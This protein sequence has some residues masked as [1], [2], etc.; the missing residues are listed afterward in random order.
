MAES[1]QY[2]PCKHEN[3]N[4]ILRP[5]INKL[6]MMVL[7]YDPALR[8]W[9]HLDAWGSLII[10]PSQAWSLMDS[11][12]QVE[13]QGLTLWNERIDCLGPLSDF[14][15]HIHCGRHSLPFFSQYMLTL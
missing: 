3:L 12:Q 2:L 7:S 10:Q 5:H 13:S 9:R 14:H 15:R 11:V 6:G 8:M 1:V 4:R